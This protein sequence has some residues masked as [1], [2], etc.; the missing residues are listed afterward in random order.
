MMCEAFAELA[1]SR[2]SPSPWSGRPPAYLLLARA[3]RELAGVRAA[4][5]PSIIFILADDLGYGDLGCY[6]QTKIKTPNLD[7]LAA[8]GMR[9]TE[10]LRRQH[11]LRAVALRADDRPAHRARA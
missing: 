3:A 10:L 5:K 6:G 9:F 1:R 7:K 11:G 2:R 8:E 4:H